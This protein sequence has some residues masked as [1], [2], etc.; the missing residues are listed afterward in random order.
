M[1]AR[2]VDYL[3]VGQ[4][5]AGSLIAYKLAS[6]G[7]S[8]LVVDQQHKRCASKIAA[9]IINPIT[10]H[11]WNLT[12]RF[13]DY[14]EYALELYREIEKD[15][16]CKL[17]HPIKQVRLVKNAGQAEY[18]QR[19]LTDTDSASLINPCQYQALKD[20]GFGCAQIQHSYWLDI[21]T[22]LQSTLNW[23]K[24]DNA[25][26]NECFNYEA[27]ETNTNGFVYHNIK[28]KRVI[29]CEGF[30]AMQNPWLSELPFKAAKGSVL[31][32]TTE[33]QRQSMLNWGN[34]FLPTTDGKAKL[35]STYEWH[36]LDDTIN[37][38]D[39][40]KLT[41][42]AT[43]F[44]NLNFKVIDHQTGI[45]PSTK[46]RKPFVGP[47]SNLNNAYCLN[48]LG[49]KGCLIAP[50]HSNH[51]SNHLEHGANIETDLNQWL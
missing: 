47:L 34:W 37:T 19:R 31:T 45:R 24:T 51:L 14:L 9:G 43:K 13:F 32:V 42:S 50:W 11:R 41:A 3:I 39:A 22:L 49:S 20:Q 46:Q 12:E 8:I 10:G 35:G 26:L 1:V 48:G 44:T 7:H 25:H 30:Q 36:K 17:I 2:S 38:D 4:G 18:L 6:N 21:Q 33:N 29:F 27:L 40:E 23:L 28:A 15:L 5:L 16:N